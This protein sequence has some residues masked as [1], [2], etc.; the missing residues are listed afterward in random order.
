MISILSGLQE[1]LPKIA[2]TLWGWGPEFLGGIPI[3]IIVLLGTGILLTIAT[4]AVQVR[5]FGSAFKLLLAGAM[6]KDGSDKKQ[7]D[8]SPFQAL[9]TSLSATVGNGNIAG[10]ASAIALGG[11]GAVFWMW[12]TAIFG[13][14]TKYS[15]AVLG[16]Q[17]RKKSDDGSMS[18]G[19]MYYCEYGVGGSFGKFLGK[20]FA[21][22]C[23]LACLIGT[24]N[25]F[26]SNSMAVATAAQIQG[27]GYFQGNPIFIQGTVGL[28]VAALVGFV[29]L[30]GVKRI[31]GVA[32]KLVPSM[33]GLYFIGALLIIFWNITDIPAAFWT[34]IKGAFT[35]QGAA[36]GLVGVGIQQA[37]RAGVARGLLSNESGLG[38]APIAHGA[39]R[40]DNPVKQGK[41]A[42]MGTFIDTLVVCTLTALVIT[43][44][45]VYKNPDLQSIDMTMAAFNASIPNSGIIVLIGSFLFGFST[46]LGWSYYGEKCTEY[47]F[48][49]SR[50][51]MGYR[52]LFIVFLFIGSLPSAEGIATVVK[53]GDIGNA[54]M[55]LP[56]LIA[57]ILLAKEVGRITRGKFA[58]E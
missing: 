52:I 11:P 33:I 27:A 32:E 28:I 2:D 17:Y 29:I 43:V 31:G 10:V 23:I 30:G 45:G 13:M 15:E 40:T 48:G 20:F 9:M 44:T 57:L 5:K 58:G 4:G 24:G 50:V 54:F 18:G 6:G 16:I 35:V 38:S 22:A 42:M 53:V 34:I 51:K 26:Q 7:G 1:W 3:L 39:A 49:T 55:A 8:I 14:A 25:M 46:L 37:I 47:L 56:N 12:I 41:I 19:P 21:V 36:G